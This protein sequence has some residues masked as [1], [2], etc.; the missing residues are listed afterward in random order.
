MSQGQ[1][2]QLAIIVIAILLLLTALAFSLA[3]A[4]STPPTLK[5]GL[6]A[7]FE[8]LYRNTGYE[9]LFAVKLALHERNQAGG[10]QGHQIELIALNDFNDPKVAVAQAKALLAD[11]DVIGVVGHVS[12]EASQAAIPV[13]QAGQMAM[14]I[15][16]SVPGA[17]LTGGDGVVSI[18]ATIDAAAEH[19]AA[20]RQDAGY[21][22]PPLVISQPITLPE[23]VTS[24]VQLEMPAVAAA[25]VLQALQAANYSGPVFGQVEVGNRQLL[26][27]AGAVADGLVFVS[28]GPAISEIDPIQRDTFVTAY[29]SLAGFPPGPRAVMAYDAAHIL[30]DSVEQVML[31]KNRWYN[32]SLMRTDVSAAL[33]NVH[34]QGLSGEIYFNHLG[35]RQSAPL[36]LYRITNDYP[37]T[38]IVP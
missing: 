16:W 24:P 13:Y 14:V 37:G 7:P 6:V 9:V 18:A 28:P 34:D 11:P 2:S 15:P 36:W 3:K 23:V 32:D 38:L 8:G 21:N 5:I 30:L 19:L 17:A 31:F 33:N 29:Q 20:A 27:T 10:I 4:Y 35:Q 22:R 26:Q 25:H 1:K 12:P